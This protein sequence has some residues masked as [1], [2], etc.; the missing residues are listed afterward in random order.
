MFINKGHRFLSC[1]SEQ[2]FLMNIHKFEINILDNFIGGPRRLFLC[3]SDINSLVAQHPYITHF[4]FEIHKLYIQKFHLQPSYEGIG[5][6]IPKFADIFFTFHI[7]F[8][9]Y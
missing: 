2:N 1:R 9:L 7:L 8:F 6:I 5:E 4:S 3:I